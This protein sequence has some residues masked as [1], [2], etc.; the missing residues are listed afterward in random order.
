MNAKWIGVCTIYTTTGRCD[1][2]EVRK[3]R[4]QNI[5]RLAGIEPA[6]SWWM[7]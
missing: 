2:A 3:R 5:N 7:I 6:S 4:D 1:K